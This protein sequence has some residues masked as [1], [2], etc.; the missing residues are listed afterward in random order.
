MSIIFSLN[1]VEA[2][3]N[4][5][6]LYEKR[7]NILKVNMT[8]IAFRN[9]QFQAERVLTRA[10]SISFTYANIPNGDVPFKDQ[11]SNIIF[12]LGDGADEEIDN[13]L[14][15]ASI[16]YSS[17]IPE[18][19]FYLG[20]G[21]GKG[22]YIAPFYKHSKYRIQNA[23][24][25]DYQRDD[26]S[27]EPLT[28]NGNVSANT[29]GLLLGAQ[30]NLGQRIVLDWWILGPNFGTHN[31]VLFGVPRR[32]LSANEQLVLKND[33]E[34][35]NIPLSETTIEISNN[36]IEMTNEGNW[37]GVRAGLSLGFRF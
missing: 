17:Y 25:L 35:I 26:G 20:K 37:G 15:S 13:M 36:S 3:G 16:G 11:L 32:L 24:I 4:G 6:L 2:Q 5:S 12:D 27:F 9:Y 19:R 18:V 33:L 7:K 21:Y 10:I 8:S 14:Y 31:G 28:T 34:D 22:V 29:F 23:E 30:F 1:S